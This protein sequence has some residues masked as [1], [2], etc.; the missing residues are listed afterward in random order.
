VTVIEKLNKA[1]MMNLIMG[2][3]LA[4]VSSGMIGQLV[5]TKGESQLN[6]KFYLL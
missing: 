4:S 3:D 6:A 5:F 2:F 1:M